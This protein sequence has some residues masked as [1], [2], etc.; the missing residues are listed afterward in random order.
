MPRS[1]KKPAPR[2]SPTPPAPELA[3]ILK[4]TPSGKQYR[5]YTVALS[6]LPQFLEERD[7]D[8]KLFFY[9]APESDWVLGVRKKPIPIRRYIHSLSFIRFALLQNRK[10]VEI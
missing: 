7:F 5:V 10:R 8:P 9:Y 3:G 1:I 6:A 4:R 2:L